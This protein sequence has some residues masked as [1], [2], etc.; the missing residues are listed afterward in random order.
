VIVVS[1]HVHMNH[2]RALVVKLLIDTHCR[3]SSAAELSK[4]K[5]LGYD[6][7]SSP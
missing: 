1:W 2:T 5:R 4:K 3:S 7:P 6:T